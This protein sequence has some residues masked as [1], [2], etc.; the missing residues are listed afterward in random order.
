MDL[1]FWKRFLRMCLPTSNI[2]SVVVSRA[3]TSFMSAISQV[4]KTYHDHVGARFTDIIPSETTRSDDW[5]DQFGFVKTL[6]TSRLEAEWKQ[7]AGQSPNFIQQKLWN[8]GHTNLYIHEWW[9]PGSNPVAARNPIPYINNYQPNN[10]YV[11]PVQQIYEDL[12][13]CGDYYQCGD[14]LQCGDSEGFKYEEKIYSHPDIADEY[15]FY[16]YV[17]GEIFGDV[18][19]LSGDD[20]EDVKRIIY[21]YKP[22][23]QRCVLMNNDG[24]WINTPYT[25]DEVWI[26]TPYT[27]TEIYINI[28]DR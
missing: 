5:S 14:D 18:V 20:L 12:P 23:Q 26:N 2:F 13:Q 9:I 16:F 19:T 28:G 3:Y 10:L 25:G 15:P 24:L 8:A 17:C 21:K 7:S 6:S 27:G 11:N 22:T 4:L 1:T